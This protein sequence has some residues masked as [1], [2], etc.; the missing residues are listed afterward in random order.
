MIKTFPKISTVT[1]M[2]VN[3]MRR[4]S[5]FSFPSLRRDFLVLKFLPP[6]WQSRLRRGASIYLSSWHSL[7]PP[8][9]P[10][11]VLRRY[12]STWGETR[13][14]N[15]FK[16]SRRTKRGVNFQWWATLCEWETNTP[17]KKHDEV[18][19]LKAALNLGESVIA[20]IIIKIIA[21]F[22]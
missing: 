18:E 2:I 13:D 14:E 17:T 9:H 22:M 19:E 10:V 21:N 6:P 7:I 5:S 12:C 4:A 1:I 8:S 20:I 15:S 11:W 3:E 16:N